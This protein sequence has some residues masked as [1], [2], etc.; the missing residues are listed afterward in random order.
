MQG[1]FEV[2]AYPKKLLTAIS[3]T[4]ISQVMAGVTPPNVAVVPA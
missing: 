4:A 1:R 2:K 3:L